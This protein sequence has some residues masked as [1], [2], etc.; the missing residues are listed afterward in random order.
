MALLTEG[1]VVPLGV[2]KHGPPG[3]GE[4]PNS[5]HPFRVGT[6]DRLD[7]AAAP[8]PRVA[9]HGN[10]GLKDATPYGVADNGRLGN[11]LLDY[12]RGKTNEQ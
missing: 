12:L 11:N 2:Y 8:S 5:R 4:C 1:G 6:I 7:L 3:G 10:P 9:E